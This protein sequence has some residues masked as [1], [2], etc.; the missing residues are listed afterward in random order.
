M[1]W[2]A[3]LAYLF[4]LVIGIY[5]IISPVMVKDLGLEIP[6]DYSWL[7]TEGLSLTPA[8]IFSQLILCLFV[9]PNPENA[10]FV[11]LEVVRSIEQIMYICV[12]LVSQ[13]LFVRLYFG[14]IK[15]PIISRPQKIACSGM[16]GFLLTLLTIGLIAT[17]LEIPSWWVICSYEW[18]SLAQVIVYVLLIIIFWMFWT[19]LVSRYYLNKKRY[20]PSDRL[21]L[22]IIFGG[23]TLTLVASFVQGFKA[24]SEEEPYWVR[25]SYTG[26]VFGI[27]V[28]LWSIGS[29]LSLNRKRLC[30]KK[31]I[32]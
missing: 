22:K 27:S 19:W 29:L 5:Y 21:L 26:L 30:I 24:F 23:L 10:N 17:I 28:L 14:V 8:T 25:G 1:R 2:L 15:Q 11:L 6:M 18:F 13:W 4:F 32:S 12:F 3:R 7:E 31:C 16:L 20:C 9:L